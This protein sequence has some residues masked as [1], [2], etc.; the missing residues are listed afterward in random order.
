MLATLLTPTEGD[1]EIAG[2]SLRKEPEKVR[3]V[4]TY[5][6]DEAGAYKNMTGKA[7][8]DFMASLF[9]ENDEDLFKFTS[10]GAAI[11]GLGD[12]LS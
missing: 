6:P 2:F 8:L 12:H 10:K 7:Y 5:L 1:A 3:K 4:I 11:C 9:A